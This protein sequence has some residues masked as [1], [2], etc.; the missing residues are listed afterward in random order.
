MFSLFG[1]NKPGVNF[2]HGVGIDKDGLWIWP[3]RNGLDL[4]SILKH[5]LYN[6]TLDVKTAH[7]LIGSSK[8]S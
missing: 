8:L 6:Q 2:V 7:E 3:K 5:C 1:L 4:V